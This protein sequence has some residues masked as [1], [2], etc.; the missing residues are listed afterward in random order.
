MY[1][2]KHSQ[3][4]TGMLNYNQ[5]ASILSFHFKLIDSNSVYN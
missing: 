1:D 5:S 3:N 2:M 4:I